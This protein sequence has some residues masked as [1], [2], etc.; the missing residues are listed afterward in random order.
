LR[1]NLIG[2]YDPSSFLANEI[3]PELGPN[4]YKISAWIEKI[5][6]NVII[7]YVKIERINIFQY[8]FYL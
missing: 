7:I 8:Y 3:S 5:H 2:P 4:E 6:C 1:P